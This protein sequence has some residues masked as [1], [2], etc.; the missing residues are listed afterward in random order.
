MKEIAS[1]KSAVEATGRGKRVGRAVYAH[2][3]LLKGLPAADRRSLVALEKMAR[4]KR[5]YNVLKLTG[6]AVTFLCYPSFF[7]EP[8]PALC[9][10]I[11]YKNGKA[12]QRNY[13]SNPPILHRKELLLPK[14]HRA[15]KRAET[16]TRRLEDKGLFKDTSI[17]GRRDGWEAM[18]R[19]AGVC[20][21]P[22]CLA[23]E[24]KP[25]GEIL[26]HKTA[27]K[28]NALSAHMKELDALGVLKRG[29][30]LLDYGAGRGDDVRALKRKGLQAWGYDPHFYPDGQK[31]RA[32]IVALGYVI[33]VI[34]D[35]KERKA[36]LKEAHRLS[37]DLLVVSARIGEPDGKVT[38]YKDG[39]KTSAGT[40]QRYFAS[41][42][43]LKHYIKRVLGE[44]VHDSGRPGVVFVPTSKKGHSWLRSSNN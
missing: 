42:D 36:V 8:F 16:L 14:G 32:D 40:F 4:A 39:V 33:N 15:I 21:T 18:L 3:A 12:V 1:L 5:R 41:G 27:I 13:A 38:R 23:R 30:S 35:A 26:R 6:D 2:A 44:E 17:I 19:R 7:V 34:E 10:S 24:R 43:D 31:K 37:R 28:R 11:T 22:A 9:M 20:V 29:V 25:S